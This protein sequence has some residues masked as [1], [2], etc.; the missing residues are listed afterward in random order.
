MQ[1]TSILLNTTDKAEH[2]IETNQLLT[3]RDLN[4][5]VQRLSEWS[6][7]WSALP[8]DLQ[9]NILTHFNNFLPDS[10]FTAPNITH[11]R[12]DRGDEVMCF[13]QFISAM[14]ALKVTWQDLPAEM[15]ANLL[16]YIRTHEARFSRGVL[17]DLSNCF[18][19][20]CFR[21]EALTTEALL[22][23]P[24]FDVHK[25]DDHPQAE[26]VQRIFAN[27]AHVLSSLNTKYA[28]LSPELQ[29]FIPQHFL[30]ENFQ[31]LPK[32]LMPSVLKMFGV[33]ELPWSSLSMQTKTV[34]SLS[35]NFAVE[36]N[37]YSSDKKSDA[38]SGTSH[39][40][41]ILQALSGLKPVYARL[42]AMLRDAIE[43]NLRDC[44]REMS[45]ESA[46]ECLQVF[47]DLSAKWSQLPE[48][49]RRAFDE[50]LVDILPLVTS[51]QLRSVLIALSRLEV[52]YSELDEE[53]QSAVQKAVLSDLPKGTD[54]EHF[55]DAI[56]KLAVLHMTWSDL[57]S[58]LKV[59][60]EAGIRDHVSTPTNERTRLRLLNSL[61]SLDV[62]CGNDSDLRADT[63]TD[64]ASKTLHNLNNFTREGQAEF[65]EL[66][67][68]LSISW[69]KIH[70]RKRDRLEENVMKQL[71]NP[72]MTDTMFLSVLSGLADMG[73]TFDVMLPATQWALIDCVSR[74]ATDLNPSEL[75]RLFQRLG[76]MEVLFQAL[77]ENTQT[78]L[79]NALIFSHSEMRPEQL[80]RAVMGL[81]AMGAS[82]EAV[83]EE[84]LTGLLEKVVRQK[85]SEQH[86][87]YVVQMI[88]TF[89]NLGVQWTSIDAH[90]SRKIEA[91][92]ASAMSR[93]T[94]EQQESVFAA[95]AGMGVE[96]ESGDE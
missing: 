70:D 58:D 80:M 53:L 48:D 5:S 87:K 12:R 59:S 17:H 35:L 33:M 77:P 82:K 81:T 61:V 55:M 75:S 15:D 93:M 85:N 67:G 26:R 38:R 20:M 1:L 78:L 74:L 8:P 32:A 84:V 76:T 52:K 51:P 47:G 89:G 44:A 16:N 64:I 37:G 7:E 92:L 72:R 68:S 56:D 54:V 95:L 25:S 83:S 49:L 60:I 19:L 24:Q 69:S 43:E 34:L 45:G 28:D 13:A 30:A 40:V 94:A 71:K 2:H 36:M 50:R 18:A 23:D 79:S 39:I 66:F 27:T 9:S 3:F 42:P 46:V 22:Q 6:L 62:S 73:V 90:H 4:Q 10:S 14:N 11:M 86:E 57:Q 88:K 91:A 29:E 96:S 41:S 31:W 63:R 65:I 21:S